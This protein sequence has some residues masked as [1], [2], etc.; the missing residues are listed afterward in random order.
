MN[1][2]SN[3]SIRPVRNPERG[4]SLILMA[5]LLIGLLSM[6]AL[7]IDLGNVYFSYRQLQAATDAAALAGAEDLPTLPL[8]LQRRRT[9]LRM[10]EI[11]TT[12]ASKAS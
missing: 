7:V 4:Q 6:A 1:R 11:K 2:K 10:W 5:G 3:R 12:T 8:Q 9:V